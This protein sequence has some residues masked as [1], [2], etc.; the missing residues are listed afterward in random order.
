MNYTC[1][2]CKQEMECVKNG[3]WIQ[4]GDEDGFIYHCDMHKCPNCD[5]RIYA[6]F[7]GPIYPD[8]RLGLR[9]KKK[10]PDLPIIKQ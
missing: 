5:N 1:V 10:L 9:L 3:V 6:G 2:T 8:E 7:G 4:E